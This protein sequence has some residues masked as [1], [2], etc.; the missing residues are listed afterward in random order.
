MAIGKILG[1]K[2][3]GGKAYH[4]RRC[5]Y[6]SSFSTV[7][8][9]SGLADPWIAVRVKG[10]VFQGVIFQEINRESWSPI[11]DGLEAWRYCDRWILVVPWSVVVCHGREMI[12]SGSS[13]SRPYILQCVKKVPCA[14][15]EPSKW[16][17][18]SETRWSFTPKMRSIV[19]GLCIKGISSSG[20][21][22]NTTIFEVVCDIRNFRVTSILS[23]NFMSWIHSELLQS[24]ES[25]IWD[26]KF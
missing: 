1:N 23:W 9:S 15:K 11:G 18:R 2:N 12:R 14:G 8:I 13:E 25:S 24:C 10:Y 21:L 7:K 19:R 3:M 16:R 22:W 5:V 17:W 4:K 20:S 6:V 26:L